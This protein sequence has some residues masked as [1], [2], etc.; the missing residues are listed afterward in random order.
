MS[1]ECD[2]PDVVLAAIRDDNDRA[3]ALGADVE[4]VVFSGTDCV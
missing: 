2:Y 1:I 4:A 3:K